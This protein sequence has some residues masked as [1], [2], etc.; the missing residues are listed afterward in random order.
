M[1]EGVFVAGLFLSPLIEN[2]KKVKV[3]VKGKKVLWQ[4]DPQGENRMNGVGKRKRNK[5]S[6]WQE[7]ARRQIRDSYKLPTNIS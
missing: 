2:Q 4:C 6:F 3:E 7:C 1:S 5:G